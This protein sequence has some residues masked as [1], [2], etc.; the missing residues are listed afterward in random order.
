MKFGSLLQNSGARHNHFLFWVRK[1][2]QL[3]QIYDLRPL[4]GPFQYKSFFYAE[5]WE[6]GFFSPPLQNFGLTFLKLPS[7]HPLCT[8]C[9]PQQFH[10]HSNIC[11]LRSS[12]LCPSQRSRY[13]LSYGSKCLSHF[14][15]STVHFSIQ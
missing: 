1:F 6:A 11:T 14:H 12:L 10:I 13:F 15:C 9:M 2:C 4:R 8:P 3:N 7:S 5:I